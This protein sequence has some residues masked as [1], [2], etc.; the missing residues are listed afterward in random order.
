VE[1]EDS[2]FQVVQQGY[3]SLTPLHLDL[4]NYRVMES[5]RCWEW[6]R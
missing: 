4:T 3:V 1:I 6:S 5:I 2:D